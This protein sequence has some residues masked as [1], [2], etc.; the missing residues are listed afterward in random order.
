MMLSLHKT[1]SVPTAKTLTGQLLAK[2]APF[3]CSLDYANAN[4]P[5][6]GWSVLID[7]E[8]LLNINPDYLIISTENPEG[9]FQ[10][11]FKDSA[12][13]KL[14]AVQNKKICCVDELIQSDTSQYAVLAYFDLFQ[15]LENLL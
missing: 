1:F 15:A 3:D 10:E 14:S 7:K 8:K 6:S 12:L 5:L 2:L 11:L 13:Q 4:G 9:V